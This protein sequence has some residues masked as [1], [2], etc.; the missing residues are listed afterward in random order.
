MSP[1]S[2][3]HSKMTDPPVLD[4]TGRRSASLRAKDDEFFPLKGVVKGVGQ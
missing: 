3:W 1:G 4:G 2:K